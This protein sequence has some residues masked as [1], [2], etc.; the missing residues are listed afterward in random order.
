MG[1]ILF[2]ARDPAGANVILPVYNRLKNKYSTQVFAKDYAWKRLSKELGHKAGNISDEYKNGTYEEILLFLQERDIDLVVTATSLDDYT[3]RYLWKAAERLHIKAFAILDQW[4]NLGIR[5]SQYDYKHREQYEKNHSHTFLPYRILAMDELAKK[6]LI[7]E[8][9]PEKKIIITGQPHFDTV[10]ERYESAHEAYDREYYNIVFVS[11]PILKDYDSGDMQHLYL[12]Y[13]EI[14]IFT[15]L[16]R[17][18]T[19]ILPEMKKNVRLIIRP[20]PREEAEKWNACQAEYSSSRIEAVCDRDTDSFSVLKAA[21]LVCGMSSMFLLEAVICEKPIMSIEIGLRQENPF[22]LEAA[23]ICKSILDE[24]TL[25]NKLRDNMIYAA[26][27][28]E[29]AAGFSYIKHAAGH[30]AAVIEEAVQHG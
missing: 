27:N 17:Q 26:E 18:I 6:R 3:E 23:G 4:I 14:T 9:V 29:H 25:Y 7:G 30:V 8:G 22:I 13:N 12:G 10:L 20:H 11:E 19:R 5:F 15:A 1:D 24:N 16:Y 2:F 21:D 28:K